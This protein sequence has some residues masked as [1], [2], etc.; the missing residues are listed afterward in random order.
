[1]VHPDGKAVCRRAQQAA[2]APA[3]HDPSGTR[4]AHWRAR[5]LVAEKQIC[6]VQLVAHRMSP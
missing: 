4:L 5:R 6:L 2:Q 1:M 3:E